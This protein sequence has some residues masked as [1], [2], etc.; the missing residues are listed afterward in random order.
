MQ[1]ELGVNA[2]VEFVNIDE[3]NERSTGKDVYRVSYTSLVLVSNSV[4]I[5]L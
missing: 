4:C 2:G 3:E 5:V 1:P